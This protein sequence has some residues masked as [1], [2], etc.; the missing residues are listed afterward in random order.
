[1]ISK[2]TVVGVVVVVAAVAA[3]AGCWLLLKGAPTGEEPTENLVTK[4]PATMALT[5]ADLPSGWNATSQAIQTAENIAQMASDFGVSGLSGNVLTQQYGYESGYSAT[6]SKDEDNIAHYIMMSSST[7]GAADLI[8]AMNVGLINSGYTSTS[9]PTIGDNCYA[10]TSPYNGILFMKANISVWLVSS[11]LLVENLTPYAQIVEDK[12]T[13]QETYM[14]YLTQAQF[15][16][17]GGN[18]FPNYDVGDSLCVKDK[19]TGITY[20][21]TGTG[22]SVT[23]IMFESSGATEYYFG[24]TLSGYNA[25]DEAVMTF[26][27]ILYQGVKGPQEFLKPDGTSRGYP[28]IEIIQHT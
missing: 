20:T 27:I 26:H 11:T 24:G 25:G 1:M 2:S 28:T 8:S 23:K 19:I 13:P 4:G 10:Y 12:I 21:E 16:T 6:Y 22:E 9:A 7:E 17:E 18:H 15:M 14:S 3:V 5:L